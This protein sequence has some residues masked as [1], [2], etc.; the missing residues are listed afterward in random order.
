[1]L[2]AAGGPSGNCEFRDQERL[3]MTREL[4]IVPNHH[5]RLLASYALPIQ[6]GRTK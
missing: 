6:G 4:D 1:M 5:F 3:G 2:G